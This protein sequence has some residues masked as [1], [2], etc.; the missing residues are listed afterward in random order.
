MDNNK[1]LNIEHSCVSGDIDKDLIT[2]KV[3]KFMKKHI[4]HLRVVFNSKIYF[5]NDIKHDN[6]CA[7]KLLQK[8]YGT[9]SGLQFKK[10]EGKQRATKYE[11]VGT[12]I[13]DMLKPKYK[14]D[15]IIDIMKN[16]EDY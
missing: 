5:T 2:G 16:T 7:F 11:I 13:Y 1:L 4:A 8:I 6:F 14:K 9:W 12:N 10:R 3:L 15:D